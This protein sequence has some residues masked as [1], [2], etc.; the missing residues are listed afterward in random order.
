MSNKY[1]YPISKAKEEI[2]N[3]NE[4]DSLYQLDVQLL[5]SLKPIPGKIIPLTNKMNQAYDN[6]K[7]NNQDINRKDTFNNINRNETINNINYLYGNDKMNMGNNNLNN[8]NFTTNNYFLN[9]GFNNTNMNFNSLNSYQKNNSG[10]IQNSFPV[11]ENQLLFPQSNHNSILSYKSDLK[12]NNCLWSDIKFTQNSYTHNLLL[13]N[14]ENC[15]LKG[16]ITKNNIINN[17]IRLSQLSY[18]LSNLGN[19]EFYKK[20][21]STSMMLRKNSDNN[22][23]NNEDNINKFI[24]N[25]I[26]ICSEKKKSRKNTKEKIINIKEEEKIEDNNHIS[27]EKNK[28]IFFNIE[29]YSDDEEQDD[30]IYHNINNIK[31]DV[32]N[33]F[34]CYLKKKKKRKKNNEVYK[35]KCLH[36]KCEFSYKTKKQLQNHHYKMTPECQLDSVQLIKLV[37]EAK[38][39]LKNIIK[40]NKNKKEK[41]EKLY[42][43]F[44]N[45]ISLK[46]YFEFIAGSHFNDD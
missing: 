20:K 29:N 13:I 6:N 22:N 9:S 41:F 12:N 15:N 32:N 33:I 39:L 21:K 28:K 19:D 43:N 3:Q 18:Q 26:N 17:N 4:P 25:E 16:N 10:L 45:K 8:N 35:H 31:N 37:H 1:N 23:Y 2:K 7:E 11:G 27:Q 46:S 36:P 24:N 5:S 38:S 30:T 34:N 44:V 40:N 42:D 14:N